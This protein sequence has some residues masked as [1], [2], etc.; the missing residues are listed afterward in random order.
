MRIKAI[1]K[2]TNKVV[3]IVQILAVV[4]SGFVCA[5]IERDGKEL[6]FDN[7]SYFLIDDDAYKT[8]T[9]REE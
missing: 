1:D 9:P 5:Y 7:P 6:K 8:L 4:Q 3:Y 2:R